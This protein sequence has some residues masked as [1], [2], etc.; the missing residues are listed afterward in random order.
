MVG[1]S[2]GS[3]VVETAAVCSL[4]VRAVVGLGSCHRSWAVV[5]GLLIGLIAVGC[6]V[7]SLVVGEA[8]GLPIAGALVGLLGSVVVGDAVGLPV[9]GELFGLLVVAT[10]FGLLFVGAGPNAYKRVGKKDIENVLQELENE[11]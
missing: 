3:L 10:E 5:V 4:V 2:V 1:G 9:V 8:V 6:S 11:T 7:G